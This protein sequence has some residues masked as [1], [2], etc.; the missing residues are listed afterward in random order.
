VT[1]SERVG[2]ATAALES[3]YEEV[4]PQM[5]RWSVVTIA[6]RDLIRT[7]AK[8]DLNWVEIAQVATRWVEDLGSKGYSMAPAA[9]SKRSHS[10]QSPALDVPEPSWIERTGPRAFGIAMGVVF[11]WF[12]LVQSL[13]QSGEL[14]VRSLPFLP[15]ALA[16]HL[17]GWWQVATGVCLLVPRF[18]RAAV[19]LLAMQLPALLVPFV[20]VPDACFAHVPYALT[21]AGESLIKSVLL[22]G[23]ALLMA[24]IQALRVSPSSS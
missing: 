18:A 9:P 16:L 11:V 19:I 22:V 3:A 7:R 21:T 10:T 13:A 5:M 24:Q 20:V 8:V 1:E 15:A 17:V 2:V 12:G 6:L 4:R 23:A 14:A